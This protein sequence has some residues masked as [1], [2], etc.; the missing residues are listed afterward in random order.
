MIA[1]IDGGTV[2]AFLAGFAERGGTDLSSVNALG[3]A[4]YAALS[5]AE[6]LSR[7][8]AASADN[9]RRFR[10]RGTGLVDTS[11][12]DYPCRL[13]AFHVAAELATHAD[14][15]GVPAARGDHGERTAWRARFS[16]FALAEA[17]PHLQVRATGARTVVTDGSVS[18]DLDDD[19]LVEGV[20]GRLDETSGLDATLRQLLST[21]P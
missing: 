16:R 15:V 3:V 6:V 19:E 10:D 20:A 13:Q 21:T 5:P 1:V 11:A 2:A 14:D 4:G 9:R 12:G 18:A 7:W 8:R 17:K